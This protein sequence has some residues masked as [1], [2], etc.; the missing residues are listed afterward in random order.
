MAEVILKVS[1]LNK[2]FGGIQATKDL[3][4]RVNSGEIHAIIGPNGAGKTTLISQLSG[5]LKPTSG[6]VE[7]EGKNITGLSI[8]KRAR[9]GLA[10]S[11]QITSVVMPMTLLENVML[12]VQGT[13]GH[14]FRFWSPVRSDQTMT[15]SALDSLREVGLEDRAH[16]VAAEVSH[17]EQRQL[18]VAMAL[19]MRPKLLLLD[20]PMAGMGVEESQNMVDILLR[21][22]Q[23]CTIL[24]I[25]HDMDAVFKLA[26]QLSVLVNGSI[27][28]SDTVTNIRANQ[29]VQR[30][31]L[32][33]QHA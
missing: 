20:E 29:E 11:F 4:L 8:A 6:S 1:E 32:G 3:N 31:Y 13:N 14:S 22:K 16:R 30:A 19:A 10:R 17:G 9:I 21:L 5:Q 24:L 12:A 28:A 18:E 23:Q 27:I 15:Q 26:D 2:S 25:E 7:F 33:E